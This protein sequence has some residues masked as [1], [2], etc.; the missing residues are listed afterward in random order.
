MWGSYIC[1]YH[2]GL[3][4]LCKFD[5]TLSF[6]PFRRDFLCA[7]EETQINLFGQHEIVLN[8]SHAS[9]VRFLND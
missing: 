6:I 5:F 3:F 7:R 1:I 2:I 4:S 8:K 9:E